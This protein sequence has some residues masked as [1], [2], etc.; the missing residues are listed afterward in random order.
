M[1]KL[2]Q[3]LLLFFYSLFSPFIV[4]LLI[5]FV[6]YRYLKKL[7]P[8]PRSG[9]DY[10]ENSIFHRLFIQFP[11]RLIKDSLSK[12]PNIFPEFG[13]HVIEG[14]QGSGKTTTIAYLCRKYKKSYPQMLLKTNFDCKIQD[15]KLIDLINQLDLSNI[16]YYGEMDCID[17]LLVEFGND[18]SRSFPPEVLQ[19]LIQERKCKRAIF[20]T[21]Q[22]FSSSAIQLRRLTSYLYTP[23]T[24]LGC[25]TIVR[26]CKPRIDK[27]GNITDKK[28]AKFFFF[29]HDTELR[30]LFDTRKI[31]KK[32]E[33]I[34]K[35]VK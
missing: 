14:E 31:I 16:H 18:I 6:Y 5:Y 23:F 32:S 1:V 30:E 13:L 17:E 26:R 21:T 35:K 10:K 11:D 4:S 20:T 3:I 34:L 25:L 12:D 33:G 19:I 24:I 9:S 22:T 15:E 27:D 7:K 28:G 2:I 29:V 8:I